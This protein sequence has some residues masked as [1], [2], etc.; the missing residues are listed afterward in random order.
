MR[1]INRCLI[2]SLL[3]LFATACNATSAVK[4]ERERAKSSTARQA[5]LT[6]EALGQRFLEMIKNTRD[7]NELTPDAVQEAIGQQLTHRAGRGSGFYTLKLPSGDWQYSVTYNFDKSFPERS[8][9]SLKQIRSR[10]GVDYRTAPCELDLHAYDAAIK[11]L[12]FKQDSIT[13]NKIGWATEINYIR[14]N[15]RVQIVPHYTASPTDGSIL[16]CVGWLS[17][18]EHGE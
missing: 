13:R 17:I 8:N 5:E 4:S 14:N 11:S 2:A 1:A 12:G 9:V 16:D 7:F 3:L 18:H 10:D 6:P 15:V